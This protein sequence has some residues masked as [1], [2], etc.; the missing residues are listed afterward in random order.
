MDF[1]VLI[2]GTDPNSYYMSRCCYEAFHKKPYVIGRS[3]LSFTTYSNILNVS[4]EED[5]WSEEGFLRVLDKFAKEHKSKIILIS[6][7]E[8]YTEFVSANKEKLNKRYIFNFPDTEVIKSLTNKENFYKTYQNSKLTFPNTIYYDCTKKSKIPDNLT[9]PIVLKP[10]N[11]VLYNHISF[12]GKKKIYKIE[13]YD[14]LKRVVNLIKENGYNDKLIMQEFI[15]GG[16]DALFDAV[17]YVNTKG[18]CEFMTFAQIGLQERTSNMVGNAAVLIN[19]FNTTKGDVKKEVKILKEFMEGINYRG[20]AEV[21]LK[22]DI[23]DN[24]F[25]VLE[26]NARQGRSSYYVAALGK[27]LVKT[28]VDD[29]LNNKE[30]KFELLDKKV[31]L[32]FVPKGIIKKYVTNQEFKSVALSLWKNVIKPMDAPC[33]KNFKRFLMLRKRWFNYYKEYK[34]SYWRS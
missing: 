6:T 20:F 18:K 15:P 14:E 26:I 12:A 29:C 28:I 21:D 11:V 8:T 19:G 13:S 22:Y 5:I 9:Y 4:Y 25:K 16:D 7:N 3:P 24:T 34:N 27:N 33:D 17:L 32:S 31:M 23:R 30:Y 10:A 1:E 2:L